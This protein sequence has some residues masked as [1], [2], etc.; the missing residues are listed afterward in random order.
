MTTLETSTLDGPPER[1]WRA[2]DVRRVVLDLGAIVVSLALTTLGVG[3]VE[4][5]AIG[6]EDASSLYVI[7]VVVIGAAR[8]T[9]PA[10]AAAV[11]AV[12]LYDVLF[13]E[14]R[15][16]L[17]VADQRE[18]LELGLLLFVALAVGR[19]VSAQRRRAEEADRRSREAGSLFA[20]SRTLATAASTEHAIPEV[21]DRLVADAHLDRVWI[22]IGPPGAE[23]S[24]GGID[25]P[26]PAA[27]VSVLVRTPGEAPARWVRTHEPREAGR[28][29]RTGA[30]PDRATY[31]IR[32]ESDDSSLGS[33]WA[34]RDRR[35]GMPSREET[36]ILAL[37][38]DQIA[39]SL[40]RDQLRRTATDLEVARQG[41][42]V[43]SALIDAI[44]HDLRTPL[45]SIRAT[46]GG[47]ADAEVAWTDEERRAAAALID[48]EADRLDRLVRTTLDLG[49]IEGGALHPDLEPHDLASMVRSVI[50]RRRDALGERPVAVDIADDVPPVLVDEALFDAV[51]T[52][53]VDNVAMHTAA[54]A[55]LRVSAD[56][57]ADDR[58]RLV[59]EDGGGGVPPD[60][61]PRLF[62]RFYRVRQTGQGSRR[63]LGIGL[64]VVRGLVEAMDGKVDAHTST[65]G[66]LAVVVTVPVAGPEPG[67]AT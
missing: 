56:R 4:E 31:R 42:G 62:E 27:V 21:V 66:G 6:I 40:R 41:D 57:A 43:K 18:W 65:L 53:L 51:L 17:Q 13:T 36:R 60:A 33:L 52:N 3:L 8:G 23:R 30:D 20:L 7:A 63:G 29:Q 50:D 22:L 54:L 28:A 64:T 67:P 24:I 46:A 10:I 34:L 39:L 48:H 5:L 38:A 55:P 37:A 49:R 12:A 25:P 47:L 11:G 2:L 35:L 26:P 32:I 61:I 59:I 14:P 58:M 19:L 1:T 15:F 16:S 45:A 44:S 9:W